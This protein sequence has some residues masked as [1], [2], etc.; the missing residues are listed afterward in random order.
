M[1]MINGSLRCFFTLEMGQ[2]GNRGMLRSLVGDLTGF[3]KSQQDL[4]GLLNPNPGLS[5]EFDANFKSKNLTR[6]MGNLPNF[7]KKN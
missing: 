2:K 1:I 7:M 5:K 6:M 4:D 3:G